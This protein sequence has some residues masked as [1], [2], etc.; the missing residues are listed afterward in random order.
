MKAG[1]CSYC[2]NSML[3]EGK[4]SL[5]EAI[6][7]VGK[8]T[9]ADC[10]EPYSPYWSPDRDVQEQAREARSLM[11][12]V[13]LQASCHALATDFAVYDEGE[14][15]ACLDWCEKMLQVAVI[16][17]ADTVRVDPRTAPPPGRSRDDIDPEDALARVA[18]S[19]QTVADIATE[20]GL[21]VGVENH[22]LL[23]GRTSQ[24]ARI[25][26]RVDRPNFGVNLDFTNFR[27][28]FGEDHV[29]AARLLACRPHPRQGLPHSAGSP[30]WGGVARNPLGR[31]RQ[32]RGRR[33]GELGLG[34]DL[35][36]PQRCGLQG[37]YLPRGLRFSG[38]PGQC[39]ERGGQSEAYHRGG[40]AVVMPEPRRGW[41]PRRPL[42]H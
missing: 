4:I 37:R 5:M 38:H 9:E 3:T 11:D 7:F 17:G 19:M 21:K 16:L 2:F 33:R 14:N 10:F 40:G 18:Q 34:R 36:H 31:I 42:P 13:G 12:R 41:K 30:A 32:A 35:S 24:T 6:E 39:R 20:K 26:E 8:E 25:V 28:V 23:L 22:G 15:R 1:V 29:E 27:T